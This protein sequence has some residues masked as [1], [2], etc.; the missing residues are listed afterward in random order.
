MIFYKEEI[1]DFLDLK[2]FLD[3]DEDT[4]LSRRGKI[5]INIL[6]FIETTL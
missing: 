6:K 5:H 4:R 3:T 2:I 1:R